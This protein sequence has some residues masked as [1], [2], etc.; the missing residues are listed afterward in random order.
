MK[1][2]ATSLF[3]S[4]TAAAALFAGGAQAADIAH[5]ASYYGSGVAA[6]AADRTVVIKPTTR[7][8]NVKN[9]ETVTFASGD[10]NFTFHFDTYP[11]T[12]VVKLNTIAPDGVNVAPVR[13]YVA[14]TRE[15]T[16]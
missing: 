10:Q 11:Q 16:E 3:L 15:V 6:K 12:Q 2:T 7:W 1:T 5:D 14:D 4:L 13:V 8:V 9:G